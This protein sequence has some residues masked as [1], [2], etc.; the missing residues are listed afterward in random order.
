MRA[1]LPAGEAALL[2]HPRA[3]ARVDREGLGHG[4]ADEAR[5]AAAARL[6]LL[7]AHGRDRVRRQ[8]RRRRRRAA[9]ASRTSSSWAC[10][11]RRR[12]RSRC[13]S[14]TSA[15][16]PRTCRSSRASSRRPSCS[17]SIAAKV[18][19]LTIGAGP[20]RRDPPRA[21]AA[22]ARRRSSRTRTSSR[23]TRSSTRRRPIHRR[24]GCPVID[25]TELSV[26][27]TAQRV[28]RLVENAPAA[29]ARHMTGRQRRAARAS[30]RTRGAAR[31][32]RIP[33]WRWILWQV[34]LVLGMLVFY[35]GLTPVWIGLRGAAWV[36]EL[37]SRRRRARSGRSRPASE[38]E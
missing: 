14:A 34:A 18:V 10:P 19:G 7:P 15:T 21:R 27:E 37:R 8:V 6:R 23:S 4:R 16:R 29:T 32:K 1:A 31:A 9:C 30:T 25:V 3:A 35:V 36:A 22:D 28:I 17:R 26:E 38:D 5:R 33:I 2:R 11:G 20:A 12:R 24:L 13:T